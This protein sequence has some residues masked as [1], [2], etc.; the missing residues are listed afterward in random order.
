MNNNTI[1]EIIKSNGL[2]LSETQ[3]L[4]NGENNTYTYVIMNNALNEYF[5]HV[6]DTTYALVDTNCTLIKFDFLNSLQECFTKIN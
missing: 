4:L 3:S 6:K 1:T 5:L 2:T